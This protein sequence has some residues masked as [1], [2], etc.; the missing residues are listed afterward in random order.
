MSSHMY[1]QSLKCWTICKTPSFECWA[2]SF[3][4]NG[5]H[6]S[7]RVYAR[8]TNLAEKERKLQHGAAYIRNTTTP[9]KITRKKLQGLAHWGW[10]IL[11]TTTHT[12]AS[13]PKKPKYKTPPPDPD[14]AAQTPKTENQQLI[15]WHNKGSSTGK[16]SSAVPTVHTRT[17]CKNHM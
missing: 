15:C 4:W 6:Y 12:T 13:I 11:D 5:K 17:I 1:N 2:I 9:E 10:D 8:R 7:R 3:F 14:A 16:N